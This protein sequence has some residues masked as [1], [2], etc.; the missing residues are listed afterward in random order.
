MKKI[1][2]LSLLFV[3]SAF[4]LS[5]CGGTPGAPTII[6]ASGDITNAVEEYRQL[7]GA[8]NNGGDPGA[9]GIN[10]YREIN[11]DSLPDDLAAPKF[12]TQ[13]LNRLYRSCR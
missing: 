3:L 11:W 10:G 5:A 9:K 2:I 8:V 6:T 7:L 1:I 12:C 13:S 4:L